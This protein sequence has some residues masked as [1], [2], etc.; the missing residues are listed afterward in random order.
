MERM[1]RKVPLLRQGMRQ[2]FLAL[3]LVL[4]VT[5]SSFYGGKTAD[6]SE[7]PEPENWI[8]VSAGPETDYSENGSDVTI[9][10]EAGLAWLAQQV[11]T[12]TDSFA[13][14]TVQLAGSLNLAGKEWTPIGTREHPFKGTFCGN[15]GTIAGVKIEAK[16]NGGAYAGLFGYTD[17]AQI[18]QVQAAGTI[19][20]T[21][22]SAND[23][24]AGGI[25]GYAR[26]TVIND[27]SFTGTVQAVQSYA[28]D[29]NTTEYI[30]NAGGITGCIELGSKITNSWARADVSAEVMTDP[31]CSAEAGGITGTTKYVTGNL[32]MKIENCWHRGTVSAQVPEGV[33]VIGGAFAGGITS[34]LTRT[35]L[36]TCYHEGMVSASG[37]GGSGASSIYAG[38][39]VGFYSEGD[40]QAGEKDCYFQAEQISLPQGGKTMSGMGTALSYEAMTGPAEEPSSLAGLLNH[41]LNLYYLAEGLTK[42]AQIYRGWTLNSAGD[43]YPSLGDWFAPEESEEDLYDEVIEVWTEADLREIARKVNTGEENYKN[44]LIKLMDSIAVSEQTEWVPIG[45]SAN[46][47]CG[48]VQGNNYTVSGLKVT[49][50]TLKS[51]GLFGYISGKETKI[52][53]KNLAIDDS[54]FVFAGD[55]NKAR[56]TGALAGDMNGYGAID[57]FVIENCHTTDRVK[58]NNSEIASGTDYAGG[59]IGYVMNGSIQFANCSNKAAI[60]SSGK[61]GTLISAY[62]GGIFGYSSGPTVI[63]DCENEGWLTAQKGAAVGGLGG[64]V[65]ELTTMNSSANKA[66]ITVSAGGTLGGLIGKTS[67]AK[68]DFVIENCR[69]EGKLINEGGA[70][71]SYT[72]GIIGGITNRTAVSKLRIESCENSGNI[73]Q[74]NTN[75][76]STVAVGGITGYI[77][78]SASSAAEVGA[79]I[80]A[81]TNRGDIVS[82]G[83]S[84]TSSSAGAD[85]G[86]ILGRGRYISLISDCKNYG[87]V[88]V[89]EVAANAY[90]GG[91]AGNL[92]LDFGTIKNSSNMGEIGVRGA[93]LKSYAGGLA[94]YV[95]TMSGNV[96]NCSNS[97]KI[98]VSGDTTSAKTQ[99]A[100]GG[101]IGYGKNKIGDFISCNNRG[102][103]SL[104]G[105]TYSIVS[106]TAGGLLGT[107]AE[108]GNLRDCGNSG[109]MSAN[110][111]A[112]NTGIGGLIGYVSSMGAT[113]KCYNTGDITADEAAKYLY[114]GGLIGYSNGSEAVTNSYNT[115]AISGT[116]AG[117]YEY[118]GG[119]G[120]YLRFETANTIDN[121]YNIGEIAAL[122][123]ANTKY[124]GGLS[125][126]ALVTTDGTSMYNTYNAGPITTSGTGTVYAGGIAGYTTY[127]NMDGTNYY[128]TGTAERQVG[129]QYSSQ[130]DPSAVSLSED[131]MKSAEF[132]ETMNQNAA[133]SDRLLTWNRS[134]SGVN[135]GYPYLFLPPAYLIS[136]VIV[137]TAGNPVADA[138]VTLIGTG[139]RYQA[140][141]DENGAYRIEQVFDGSYELT[142][143]AQPD[144]IVYTAELEV[145]GADINGEKA[146]TDQAKQP[147]YSAGGHVS[148]EGGTSAKGAILELTDKDGTTYKVP[149]DGSGNY[150]TK[151][152]AGTYEGKVV[153][154]KDGEHQVLKEEI[155]IV[156]TPSGPNQTDVDQVGSPVIHIEGSVSTQG[157]NRPAAGA[158]ITLE[159]NDGTV[160]A[161]SKINPD[162]SYELEYKLTDVP[163]S[164]DYK[165]AVEVPTAS[166]TPEKVYLKENITIADGVMNAADMRDL[167]KI[168]ADKTTKVKEFEDYVK[169]QSNLPDSMDDNAVLSH[170]DEIK[171]AQD[172]YHAL[173][174]E[175]AGMTD[176]AVLD[177]L[178]A[179]VGRLAVLTARVDAS[180]T[181]LGVTTDT[182][183][184]KE[185]AALAAS[186]ENIESVG[187]GKNVEIEVVLTVTDKEE[188][189]QTITDDVTH[190]NNTL[191][192]LNKATEAD[193]SL[194]L[195]MDISLIK[196]VKVD[197]AV[198]SSEPIAHTPKTTRIRLHLPASMQGGSNYR[199][200][201][202]HGGEPRMINADVIG[203]ELVFETS[204]YST[205]AILY[206]PARNTNSG[207]SYIPAVPVPKPEEGKTEILLKGG[208]I[209]KLDAV[210]EDYLNEEEQKKVTEGSDASLTVT[211]KEQK[212]PKSA[213]KKAIIKKAGSYKP[214]AYYSITGTVKIGEEEHRILKLGSKRTM[215]ITIPKKLRGHDS[216]GIVA[217]DEN[218]KAVFLKDTDKQ[219]N[220][221]TVA[222]DNLNHITIVYKD[223][224]VQEKPDKAVKPEVKTQKTYYIV[225]KG[226]YLL[227][228][229]RRYNVTLKNLLKWNPTDN[230]DLIYPD[231]K[232]VLYVKKKK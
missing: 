148:Y 24:Y 113:E 217:V 160:I 88:M 63:E 123:D 188:N 125:G 31:Y 212:K 70:S 174:P 3:L 53:I 86:G 21:V 50:N 22:S 203:N 191:D 65:S 228:I 5:A 29:S 107:A 99:G 7:L 162:G 122:G 130:T 25:V 11:N 28:E 48:S 152:P 170:L 155:T 6:A 109:A 129:Y 223:K 93:K 222:T 54:Q 156:V 45:T 208:L 8:G 218:Q 116:G 139:G 108:A 27:V 169:N 166:G 59:L 210:K 147:V 127:F 128:L 137:D 67:G 121:S 120:G 71:S 96:E 220:T 57:D 192:E 157:N 232:L 193:L 198:A 175:E 187:D 55:G 207:G 104:T 202:V 30:A 13:G 140:V 227:K 90:A 143:T 101:L 185:I 81:C 219:K 158:T 165:V 215:V 184:L 171:N 213:L 146:S 178:G 76:S 200:V 138:V 35:R 159:T 133:A 56:H 26:Q 194:G 181:S 4:A 23:L 132:T 189:D 168:E 62:M 182:E 82:S 149:I 40:P 43:G 231:Q 110:N 102:D 1:K 135:Q 32:E 98:Q 195:I 10:N 85:A 37:S 46:P 144:Q 16:E 75:T 173:T 211:A 221:I 61:D 72:G 115:G 105:V 89:G 177:K 124:A 80:I 136:G 119:I 41:R 163:T 154:E 66:D 103:V 14:K 199:V 19:S 112:G 2:R 225:K 186:S 84:S 18:N 196:N 205:Y 201:G 79:E 118:C 161:E 94:G 92:A 97:G 153:W 190:I 69:N 42:E 91:V 73:E 230:P 64:Q 100:A 150:E 111:I 83:H 167:E 51:A 214:G 164:G 209:R 216:Y 131:A 68:S 176:Y 134:V 39:I 204:L 224:K 145:A 52:S 151:L 172:K 117:N 34:G 197:G 114:T 9:K 179:L 126:N 226:D 229:A 20:L 12:G 33:M 142:V 74:K 60:E 87:S 58:I 17:G 77:E 47:F 44:K 95:E 183:A 141:T 106:G 38:G 36:Q 206:T 78:Y 180:G 49:D 15:N